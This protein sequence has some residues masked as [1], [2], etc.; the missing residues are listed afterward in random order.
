MGHPSYGTEQA[1][2]PPATDDKLNQ[3]RTDKSHIS[4]S[5][6]KAKQF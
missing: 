1:R 3:L 2:T 6:Q 5:N 4:I